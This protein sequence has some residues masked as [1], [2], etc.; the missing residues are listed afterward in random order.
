MLNGRALGWQGA[1][2]EGPQ[3]WIERLHSIH[4]ELA[5]LSAITE[6]QRPQL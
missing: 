3:E 1:P 2:E 6:A 4:I 5:V